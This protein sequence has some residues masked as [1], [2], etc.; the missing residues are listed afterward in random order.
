MKSKKSTKKKHAAAAPISAVENTRTIYRKRPGP[1]VTLDVTADIIDAS[2]RK[3]SSHCMIAETI[4]TCVP[5]ATRI[6][7]DL[8]TI[9]WSDR[10]KGLRYTYLTPR[11]AQDALVRFDRG[12]KPPPFKLGLRGAQ[13]TTMKRGPKGKQKY[14]H[15]LGRRKLAATK[16]DIAQGCVPGVVGG[17]PPPRI[18]PGQRREF[19]LRAFTL[20]DVVPMETTAEKRGSGKPVASKIKNAPG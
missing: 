1:N 4:R 17:S 7:V 5:T 6:S 12:I 14:V 9:R 3:S 19:G 11:T 16:T 18:R 10:K 2:T 13:V 15:K 8:A 20:E